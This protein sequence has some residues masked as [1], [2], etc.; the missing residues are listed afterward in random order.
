MTACIS[1]H[2]QCGC[3]CKRV[4]WYHPHGY[5]LEEYREFVARTGDGFTMLLI[6]AG[7]FGAGVK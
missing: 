6:R 5:T 1:T 7:S 2:R 4:P 3:P